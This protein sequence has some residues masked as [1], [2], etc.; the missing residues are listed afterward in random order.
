MNLIRLSLSN[1][2]NYSKLGFDFK[3]PVTVLIG[4]NA[5]G[6]TN[7]LESIFF[8]ATAKSLKSDRDEELI[9]HSQDVLRIEG[10]LDN[11][12]VIAIAMQIIEGSLKKKITVNGIPRR[13]SE[14]SE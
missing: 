7:F 6:K 13:V 1:F 14:Y 5:Q 10:E 2:R 11:K 12:I 3:T 8:L 9:N 4:D